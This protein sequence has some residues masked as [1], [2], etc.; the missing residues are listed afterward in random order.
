[1]ITQ[2]QDKLLVYLI[3][4]L[5]LLLGFLYS[6]GSDPMQNVP[7]L[8]LKLQTNA[9]QSLRSISIDTKVLENSVFKS[10]RVFGSLPVQPTIGGTSNPF[11]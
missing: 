10:L 1:M 5:G 2:R 9:L 11:E 3:M 6:N 7:V 8:D 4:I